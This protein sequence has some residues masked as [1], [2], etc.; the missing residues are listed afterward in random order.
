M[1]HR[2]GVASKIWLSFGL[3]LSG[4]ILSTYLG[5]SGGVDTT[6]NLE[7]ASSQLF[8]A[9]QQSAAIE[10]EYDEQTK[11]Y[12][13]AVMMGEVEALDTAKERIASCT[14]YLETILAMAGLSAERRA[15]AEK[16][17][18]SYKS[19]SK[20][21]NEY[22]L[23]LASGEGDPSK[24]SEDHASKLSAKSEKLKTEFQDLATACAKDLK[25][26]LAATSAETAANTNIN[27]SVFGIA[28]G[29]G[30]VLCFLIVS[31]SITK[32][33]HKTIAM[34]R[35]I[36]EGTGDLTARL[37][38]KNND[39]IGEVGEWFN[40]FVEKIHGV[41]VQISKTAGIVQQ[42]ST[43]LATTSQSLSDGV[44]V[45][46]KQAG[47]TGR[48]AN[49][50]SNNMSEL[51]AACS[52]VSDGIREV[53][54]SIEDMRS[55][56][57]EIAETAEQA[58]KIARDA[59]EL[60]EVSHQKVGGLSNAANEIGRVIEVIQDI[61]EQTN[62]LALNA[63]IEAARAGAAGKGFA[64]VATEVK[65]LSSQTAAATDDIRHRIEAIQSSATEAV[66]SIGE[67][68]GVVQKVNTVSATIA[69]SV[70]EQNV[71]TQLIASNVKSI[72]AASDRVTD[73]VT[74]SSSAS[75]EINGSITGIN[76]AIQ[77][78]SS[79]T[80]QAHSTSEEL[81][82]LSRDLQALV[83]SFKI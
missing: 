12:L 75:A 26:S 41:V 60:A 74:D 57:G 20:S 51:S 70:E 68:S 64:V 82:S 36:A 39:E 13:E 83:S 37:D 73:G 38:S 78:T 59:A 33:L 11:L 8:P 47:T 9:S 54:T 69:A 3:L 31:R 58:S 45:V 18:S 32:P 81:A 22:Y 66:E 5:Y 14:E 48:S 28:A 67:I 34:L 61:A 30:V 65:E 42:S 17:L 72:I 62:L 63:T 10:G 29:L 40:I 6:E 50:M 16:T 1:K 46:I 21:A 23:V 79:A 44:D 80:E 43:N 19:Y 24:Y 71:T 76:D 7:R 52:D 55:N 53:G 4:Y 15:Q 49:E 77:Q 25:D 2:L 56:I 35:N 27:L